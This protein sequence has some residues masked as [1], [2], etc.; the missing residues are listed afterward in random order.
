MLTGAYNMQSYYH[1]QVARCLMSTRDMFSDCLDARHLHWMR[2]CREAGD[3]LGL[4]VGVLDDDG[5]EGEDL[6]RCVVRQRRGTNAR[7]DIHCI[8]QE[9]SEP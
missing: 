8:G 5:L 3:V 1:E 6:T 7:N 4:L 9:Q 2:A